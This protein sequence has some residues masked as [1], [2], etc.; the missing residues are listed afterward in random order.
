LVEPQAV[1]EKSSGKAKRQN[2]SFVTFFEKLLKNMVDHNN[3]YL[4]VDVCNLSSANILFS[5]AAKY[6]TTAV[7]QGSTFELLPGGNELE[8]ICST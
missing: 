4:P 8:K 6:A 5:S 3:F 1:A 2:V 7:R